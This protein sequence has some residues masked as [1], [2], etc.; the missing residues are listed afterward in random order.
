MVD[1]RVEGDLLKRFELDRKSQIKA[2][3]R[4]QREILIEKRRAAEERS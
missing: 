2:P 1:R 4:S 3:I